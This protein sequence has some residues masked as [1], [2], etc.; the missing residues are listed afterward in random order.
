MY[1][2]AVTVLL[3]LALLK[4]VDVI[5][6]L[7]PGLAR[8]RGAVTVGLAVAGAFAVDYSLFEGFG[9]D[10]REAWAGTLLTGLVVAGTTSLW[11]AVLVWLGTPAEEEPEVPRPHRSSVGR[12]A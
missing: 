3:G 5:V 12:A 1:T 7:A 8:L 9:V 11:R 10:L 6:G 4:V 2:F